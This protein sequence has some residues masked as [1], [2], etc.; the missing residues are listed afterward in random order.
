MRFEEPTVPEGPMI[1][2]LIGTNDQGRRTLEQQLSEWWTAALG[3]D[4][5]GMDDDIF[6]CGCDPD[7]GALVLDR[8]RHQLQIELHISDLF[9][10]RTISKL[11]D[12]IEIRQASMDSLSVIPIRQ[13]SGRQPLVLIHGVGGNLLGFVSLVRLLEADQPV[14]GIQAQAL[15][16]SDPVLVRLES[17]AAYYIRE[18]RVIQP[19][20]P[21]AFLGLSFGGLVAYEMAQQLVAA[22]ETVNLVGMLDTWQP[23]YMRR[24]K[25]EMPLRTRLMHRL[26]MVRLNTRKLSARQTIRYTLGRMKGRLLRLMY[27]RMGKS[28]SISLPG[29]MRRVRDINLMAGVRYTV[30]PYP[31]RITLFRAHDEKD[32][33]LPRDLGWLQYARGGVEI[34]SLPGDHGQVLS[35]PNVSCLA[36]K[37]TAEL[38]T[39]AAASAPAVPVLRTSFELF[40]DEWIEHVPADVTSGKAQPKETKPRRRSTVLADHEIEV[41]AAQV[42]SVSPWL[43]EQTR[44]RE[45]LNWR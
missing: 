43:G 18:L 28:S 41:L 21:Y 19:R 17:M 7:R 13:A 22:G 31:G 5:I 34:V 40:N 36:E 23:G 20:G 33:T 39:L 35:E 38:S 26:H 29:S 37:L 42:A 11:A 6:Q 24:V 8:I 32:S 14:Y 12:L 1:T 15:H 44:S 27:L 25:L 16:S 45:A 30:Q 3:I 9:E 4:V 10:A 2:S